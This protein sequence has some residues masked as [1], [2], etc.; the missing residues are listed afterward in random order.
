MPE[1]KIKEIIKAMVEAGLSREEMIA[2]LAE[3]GVGEPEKVIAE[4]LGEAKP[5][6]PAPAEAAPSL[7]APAAEEKA[8]PL[9]EETPREEAG[10]GE[11]AGEAGEGGTAPSLEAPAP[12]ALGPSAEELS[13]RLDEVLA[14]LKALQE[15]DRQVLATLREVLLRIRQQ[16]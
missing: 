12:L 13:A 5:A 14:L 4:V 2:D 15:V 6:P 16:T 10:E 1:D 9:F 3:I 11:E 8:M 7:E